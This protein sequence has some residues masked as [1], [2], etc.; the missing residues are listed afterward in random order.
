MIECSRMRRPLSLM[1]VRLRYGLVL[2]FLVLF[3]AQA[4]SAGA[5]DR[6]AAK[7]GLSGSRIAY[8]LVDADSG[9]V[10]ESLDPDRAMM[11]ASTIKLL[12]AL[13]ALETL[14]NEHRLE[15]RLWIDGE[16]DGG[17]LVGDLIVEGGGDVELDMD[18]LLE[19]ALG[20]RAAG[21]RA[22]EGRFLLA[23][24]AFLRLPEVNGNQPVDATYNAGVGPLALAFSRVSMRP[25]GIGNYTGLPPL[26]ERGPAWSIV[27]SARPK[28]P[29]AIPVRDAG[30]HAARNLASLIR[31]LGIDIA[32]PERGVR[33]DHARLLRAVRSKPVEELVEDMLLYSNNQLAETLGLVTSAKLGLRAESL[34]RSAAFVANVM[35]SRVDADWSGLELQNHSG[36]SPKTRASA[37]QLAAI[38]RYGLERHGLPE[39]LPA[40][41]WS[42]SLERRLVEDGTALRVWAKTGSLD[43]AS[44]LA[45]Y[46]LADGGL[47]IF[48]IMTAEEARRRAYDAMDVPTVAIRKEA[49]DWEVRARQYQDELV[50]SWIAD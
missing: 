31:R 21:I 24:D 49:D 35:K 33:P 40:S 46:L 18:D 23:D 10:L 17:R 27:T 15:T 30:M 43:F 50:R 42:G 3:T 29:R 44:A 4:G 48:V 1:E 37:A 45:G 47:R 22:V 7:H 28:K 41:A 34:D 11:P 13:A 32:D 12:T 6:L 39:L 19:L 38:L 36:L 9:D 14:G 25:D 8:L 20:L 16:L 2:A 26:L 5:D